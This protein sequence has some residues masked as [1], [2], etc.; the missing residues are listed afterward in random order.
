[1]PRRDCGM[2]GAP[3]ILL[4]LVAAPIRL[5]SGQALKPGPCYKASFGFVVSHPCREETA[6]WMGHP[7]S[8]FILSA[9]GPAKGVPLLQSVVW[10]RGFPP[11][12]RRDCGMDGAPGVELLSPAGA[13]EETAKRFRQCE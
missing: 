13:E 8:H 5:R 3:S 2:D 1:M 4:W 11:M 6:A 9:C 10:V 7:A 12:P